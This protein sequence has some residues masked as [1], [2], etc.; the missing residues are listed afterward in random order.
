MIITAALCWWNERPEDL[1]RCVRGIGNIADRIIALDGSYRRYPGATIRSSEAEVEAIC[2][3]ADELGI[4]CQIVQPDR[5]WAGQVE[6]R[7]ELLRLASQNTDWIVTVDTD[8]VIFCNRREARS[9]I[10]RRGL[11]D[12]IDI[13]DVMYYTPDNPGKPVDEISPGKWHLNQ[14]VGGVQIP[15]IWR[16]L[17][18]MRVER[19]HWWYS[20][21]KDGEPVWLWGGDTDGRRWLTHYPLGTNYEVQH[22]CLFRTKEQILASRA[23]L[24]DREMVVRRTGQEDDQPGL[25]APEWD[26]VSMPA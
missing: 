22:T 25:P 6:K 1:I 14:R 23:F 13:F 11:N 4:E 2:T 8:H 21:R 3:T 20:A 24:N 12:T 26:Y 18:E 7:T 19:F 16:P 17:P 9:E 5:I 10:E 15:H